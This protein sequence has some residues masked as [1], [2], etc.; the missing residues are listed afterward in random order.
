[1]VRDM[2]LITVVLAA[3]H[4]VSLLRTAQPGLALSCL[5]PTAVLAS[6]RRVV[7]PIPGALLLASLLR[8]DLPPT[9]FAV[10]LPS[11]PRNG[12]VVE[13]G[14]HLEPAE[15]GD[16]AQLPGDPGVHGAVPAVGIDG[17][18]PC[19]ARDRAQG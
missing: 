14:V 17:V 6:P 4:N 5:L 15:S 2:G 11:V 19:G 10:P 3:S 18:Q 1:M 13:S 8:H 7:R 9:P 12:A 16:T